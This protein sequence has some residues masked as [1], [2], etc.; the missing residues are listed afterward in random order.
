MRKYQPFHI[1][2]EFLVLLCFPIF[3]FQCTTDG[4]KTHVKPN[5]LFIAVDDLRPEL[6][7][8]GAT[9]IKS[10]N[11]D[12]LA[13]MSTV[14]NRA[15]C[16]QAVCAPSRNSIMTG[17]RPDAMGIYDLYTFFREKVPEV[18]T[19]PQHF[20]KHGY[21]TER[22][23]KIYH[24]GH[25][26]TDDSL[27][28]SQPASKLWRPNPITRGD[29]VGLERD[30]PTIDGKKLPYYKSYAPEKNMSDV[31]STDYA[32]KRIGEL[33]DTTFFFAVGFSKPHLP[34]VAPAKYWDMYDPEKIEIPSR[35][36]PD[37]MPDLALHR[38]GE[39]RKYHDIPAEGSLDDEKTRNLIHGYYAAV[40][41]V[42]A[43]IGKLL[44]AL[45]TNDLA[46]NTIIVLW[47][48]H[49]WKLG[50]YGSWCK[51][52]NFELDTRVPLIIKDPR[53]PYGQTTNSLAEF[54][55]VY[56]TI[57][58]MAGLPL[59][60]H[61]EGQSLLPILKNSEAIVNEVAISQYPRGESLG[62]DRK[63]EIMG[64]SMRYGDYRFTR[65]QK[66][67]IPK[68]V[69]AYE[70][71]DH[72][73]SSLATENLAEHQDYNDLVKK[74]DALLTKELGRYKK[75]EFIHGDFEKE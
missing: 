5:V 67:E 4:G 59:P 43:Q 15:Y 12:R 70:L 45:A 68:D 57:C 34:F 64:Y 65:W 1:K 61:I 19:L 52:T 66:Y 17:L 58:E 38:F 53:N 9:H 6:N 72:S 13:S 27:S 50:D 3:L 32:A 33:K 42:D 30:Y 62:Y 63:H 18:V 14:F 11:I 22:I 54:V 20:K 35:T 41:M 7:C 25:G 48:D 60:D 74:M 46:D 39:L 55:D 28:W 47:G 40:S 2:I 49:G 10:P 23:G 36:V 31:V 51:H 71:Y 69:V 44:N 56:P 73:K 37:G 16:Q 8:Y 26:N 75:A 29:T 24:T 21:Y